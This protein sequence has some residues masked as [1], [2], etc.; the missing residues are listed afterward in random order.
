MQNKNIKNIILKHFHPTA[1]YRAAYALWL[2]NITSK[3]L[4]K[5]QDIPAPVKS[6]VM[7]EL[8]ELEKR[9]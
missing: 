3:E 8:I 1:E 2:R 4:N 9:P 5:C 7:N 6:K